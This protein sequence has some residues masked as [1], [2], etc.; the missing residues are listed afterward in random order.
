V[1]DLYNR[2]KLGTTVEVLAP[3]HYSSFGSQG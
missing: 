3:R 2:V 1:I